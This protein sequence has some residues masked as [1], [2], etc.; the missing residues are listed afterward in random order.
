MPAPGEL[1]SDD[2]VHGEP[3]PKHTMYDRH[4]PN[5]DTGHTDDEETSEDEGNSDEEFN[6]DDEEPIEMES[7]PEE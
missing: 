5:D 7:E 2:D 3:L 1:D 6:E 4:A